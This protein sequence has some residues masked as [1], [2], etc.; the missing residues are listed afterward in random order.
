MRSLPTSFQR[1]RSLRPFAACSDRELAFIVDRTCEYRAPAGDVLTAEGRTG[2]EWIV[3]VEGTAVVR[4]GTDVVARLGPGDAIGEVAL[5]DHGPRTA[6]VVAE[7]D[8]EVLV[9]SAAEF[10]EILASVPAVARTI[11]VDL[12]TR[13]RAADELLAQP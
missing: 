4:V 8:V 1:I 10:T 3:L 5:L 7:T 9:A 12:A 6:T 2:R 11:L 13:L